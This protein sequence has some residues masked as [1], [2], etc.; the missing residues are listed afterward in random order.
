MIGVIRPGF[1]DAGR[2]KRM[3]RYGSYE[4]DHA[5]RN[6]M[7]LTIHYDTNRRIMDLTMSVIR[8]PTIRYG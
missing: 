7:K 8:K 6:R 1:D 5:I 4:I 3:I 2:T